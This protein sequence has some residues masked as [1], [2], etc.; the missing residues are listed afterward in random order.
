MKKIIY[1]LFF[2]VIIMACGSKQQKITKKEPI[3]A[4]PVKTDT[5]K[6]TPASGLGLWKV[7]RYS[8]TIGNNRNSKYITNAYAIWGTF[9]NSTN[10]KAE[11]KVKFLID[12]ETFCIKLLEFGN[13]AV[14]RGDE[15]CYKIKITSE[16][17]ELAE[18]TAKNVSDRLF[19][20][21][22]DAKKLIELFNQGGVLTFLL[23]TDSKTNPTTYIFSIHNPEGFGNALKQLS[24]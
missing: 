23:V 14:K 10:D 20:V 5:I 15:S 12:K 7:L 3:K 24:Q 17:N 11:L 8:G 1:L 6:A 16:G 18:F 22:S 9:C 21:D 2:S 13:K 19:I 4:E